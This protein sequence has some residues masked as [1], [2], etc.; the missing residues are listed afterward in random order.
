MA[1]SKAINRWGREHNAALLTYF[2]EHTA[3]GVKPIPLSAQFIKQARLAIDPERDSNN[4]SI[5]YKK[6]CHTYNTNQLRLDAATRADR[7]V[8]SICQGNLLIFVSLFAV[9]AYAHI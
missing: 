7:N 8:R 6:H 4:F 3:R 2:E 5:N 9:S 1:P